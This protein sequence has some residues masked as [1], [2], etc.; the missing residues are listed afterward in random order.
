MMLTVSRKTIVELVKKT[1]ITE[2]MSSS[3][4]QSVGVTVQEPAQVVVQCPT[5]LVSP[6]VFTWWI[7]R[8]SPTL[9]NV[10]NDFATSANAFQWPVPIRVVLEVVAVLAP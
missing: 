3:R 1:I 9:F 4:D 2:M 6:E 7:K 8:V 10:S 5:L